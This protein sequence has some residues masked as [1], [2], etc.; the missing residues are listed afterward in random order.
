M[1]GPLASFAAFTVAA[2][3]IFLVV[4]AAASLAGALARG[5][6]RE[7]AVDAYEAL[8]MS[9]FTIP[10]SIIVPVESTGLVEA[11]GPLGMRGP[12]P[13]RHPS[14]TATIQAL[15]DLN[16]PELEIIVVA[17]RVANASVE[18]LKREWALEPKELFYRR[19]IPTA[20]VHRIYGSERES[21]LL[22]VEK[23]AGGRAD[24]L[25]CGASVARFRYVVAVTPD[26]VFDRDALLRLMAPA[27][28][29]PGT[30]LAVTSYVERRHTAAGTTTG[31]ADD[32]TAAG[33]DFQRLRSIRSWMASRLAWHQLR[34]GVPPRDGVAA[35]R[36]DTVLTLGGFSLDAADPEL[37]LLVR[38]QT[39]PDGSTGRVVRTSEVFGHAGVLPDSEVAAAAALRRRALHEAFR[40][41]SDKEVE[42][43]RTLRV[44]MKSVLAV[45]LITPAAQAFALAAI[46]IGTLF[47]VLNWTAPFLALLYLTFG[48]GLVSASALLLRGGTPGAPVGKDL[49]RLLLRAPL[50]FVV[51]MPALLYARR[52]AR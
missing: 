42:G 18:A 15:L 27:L 39:Q 40:T 5:G 47:G 14:L 30:V 50:E 12:I 3:L 2:T 17:D 19:S 34:C 28:R 46:L 20:P 29:D 21:R 38:L 41:L 32:W 9:R 25:N 48:Y 52:S 26:V 23:A 36:R 16:Y 51:Y 4:I 43:N 33:E 1:F 44:L 37:D 31:A 10:V 13:S 22:V 49:K 11:T 45:E 6:R 8:A 24:A 35:F 7:R